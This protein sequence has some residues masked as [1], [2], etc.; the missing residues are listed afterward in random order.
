MRKSLRAA[1]VGSALLAILGGMVQIAPV[2]AASK[3]TLTFGDWGD[4]GYRDL[5]KQYMKAHPEIT[6]VEKSSEYNAHHQALLVGL[7]SGKGNDINGVEG[8]QMPLFAQYAD[9]FLDLRQYGADKLAKTYLS[10]RWSPAVGKQGQVIGIPTDTG[11]LAVAYRQDLFQAAGLPTDPTAVAALWS[12]TGWNG[13]L[14]TAKKYAKATNGK[15]FA[16][17]TQTVFQGIIA[18]SPIEYYAKNGKLIYESSKSVQDAWSIASQLAPY[19]GSANIF[20]T[21]W[22]AGIGNGSYACVLAP[23]WMLGLIRGAAGDAGKGKWNVTT[24]PGGGGNWGG[25]WL[26]VSKSTQ[27]P[28]EAADLVKWLLA[29][30]QQKTLFLTK[31]MFP[32][33]PALL[34]DPAVA[35]FKDAY[36]N[37]APVGKIYAASM[38]KLQPPVIGPKQNSI[39]N[40]F[41]NALAT[42]AQGKASSVEA[43]DAAIADIVKNV[44]PSA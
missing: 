39:Q 26:T 30:A 28:K 42:V 7:A 18:Q 12:K 25:S 2:Q 10:W 40:S 6:I 35:G 37:N 31:T 4:M 15:T 36:F 8:A 24:V 9:K 44:G 1:A 13:F 43:W 16:D 19:T 41:T 20:S 17:S 29:P 5:F 21:E 33:V 3:I 32:S 11:G 22:N 14:A 27:H 23:A 38:L 34:K